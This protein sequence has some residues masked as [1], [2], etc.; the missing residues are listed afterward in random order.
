MYSV[1]IVED[2]SPARDLLKKLGYWE[3]IKVSQIYE[4]E[5]AEIGLK[6]AAENHPD[7]VICDMKMPE[8][9]GSYFLRELKK[10]E[11]DPQVLIVSAY[12][13]FEYT[14]Q[15][16]LSRVFNYLLKP[17][18][19]I[20]FNRNLIEIYNILEE[21]RQFFFEDDQEIT[22]NI[23]INIRKYVE[24]NYSVQ[25]TLDDLA[26]KFYSS[27]E[28]ISRS[29]KKEYKVRLFDYINNFRLEKVKELLKNTSMSVDE[30]ALQTGFSCGNYLSKVFKKKFGISPGEYRF[31]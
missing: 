16:I 11:K 7:I 31:T 25:I 15:A 10:I 6:I 30:I 2:E 23:A 28:H 9:D 4:A 29:F 12:T 20:E 19:I 24:D 8:K 21:K 27:K 3:R 1:L 26:R 17:I 14:Q 5:S 13:D 22:A 18:D